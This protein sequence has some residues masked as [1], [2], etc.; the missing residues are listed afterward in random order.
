METVPQVLNDVVPDLEGTTTLLTP[1]LAQTLAEDAFAAVDEAAHA[2]EEDFDD[3]ELDGPRQRHAA[4]KGPKTERKLV[5]IAVSLPVSTLVHPRSVFKGFLPPAPLTT[6]RDAIQRLLQADPAQ[7]DGDFIEFELENFACYIHNTNSTVPFEMRALH[8]HACKSG[9]QHFYFDGILRVGDTRLYVHEIMFEEIPLGNYGKELSTVDDQLW[10]RSKLNQLKPIYYQ[11]KKPSIEY[12]R[13]HNAFLWV[14][15]L[16]KHVVDFCEWYIDNRWNISIH[17]FKSDFADWLKKTHQKDPL[18]LNWYTKRE[19]DDFRQSLVANHLFIR[20]EVRGM[21]KASDFNRLHVF[22]EMG[23]PFC[24]Y[25]RVGMDPARAKKHDPVPF[26]IVTPYIYKCFSHMGLD[27]LLRAVEPSIGTEEAIK[28]SWPRS[29][30]ECLRFARTPRI[31]SDR[32]AMIDSIKPGDLISTPP[33]DSGTGT[34]WRTERA[35]KKWFGLVQKVHLTKKEGR[36]FDVAWLYQPD[37]TPC[38]AAK[39]PWEN[40]LFLSNHCTCSQGAMAKIDEDEVLQVH[41]VE[42]FGTPETSAEFFV[43]QLY[44]TEARRFVTLQADHLQCSHDQKPKPDFNIGDTVLVLMPGNGIPELQPFE[45][46]QYMDGDRTV[47]LRRFRRRKEFDSSCA[48]N[49]LVYTEEETSSWV[50]RITTRCIIRFYDPGQPIPAPYSRHGAGNAFYITHRLLSDGTVHPLDPS[51]RPKLRE[52]FD[53]LKRQ[54]KLRSLDLFCGC[55]NFGRGVEDSGA[56]AAKWAN[57]IKSSAIHTYMANVDPRSCHP[58]L[59]SIDDLL[60]QSMQGKF[61]DSVPR[62]GEVDVVLGG[63]PCQGFSMLTMNKM[64]LQQY[65]NRSLVASFAACIDYWRPRWGILENVTSIVKSS[66]KRRDTEDFFSQLICA[67]IGMGY[68]AQIILGDAWSYGQPQRRVRAFL[69]FAAPGVQLP[70]PPYPSH[71]TPNYINAVG[72]GKMTNGEAY[73]VRDLDQPTAFQYVSASEATADLPDIYDAKTETCIPYPDHRLSVPMPSGSLNGHG[74]RGKSKRTQFLNIPITPYGVN[75]AR[76]YYT[77][78]TS[79]GDVDMFEHE[80]DAF[81]NARSGRCTRISNGWGRAHPRQLFSTITTVC[82]PTDARVGGR[83]S[84]W[85]QPRHLSVMEVRRAQGIPDEEVV[86][87]TAAEQWAMVGNAV[88]RGIS[89]ALGLSLR[90]AWLGTL[91]E[92]GSEGQ[93][94][95]VG[96]IEE[97]R[98]ELVLLSVPATA[99]PS[100]SGTSSPVVSECDTGP[101]HGRFSSTTPATSLA[102]TPSDASSMSGKRSLSKMLAAGLVSSTAFKRPKLAATRV[103][104]DALVWSQPDLAEEPVSAEPFDEEDGLV[105]LGETMPHAAQLLGQERERVLLNDR[106]GALERDEKEMDGDRRQLPP[107]EPEVASLLP[108]PDARPLSTNGFTVVRLS[109]DELLEEH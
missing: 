14:A 70:Q 43:R 73:V 18:F 36:R 66:M 98:D 97:D 105:L 89:M 56:V 33:D 23:M 42:W 40:E 90:E 86:L 55:G 72:L 85:E 53:P 1:G 28:L 91:Y 15:D 27:Q 93:G 99:A 54:Q 37:D 108:R 74:G 41:S 50:N 2:E 24:M 16:A 95:S 104:E 82:H 77:P 52:G 25:K 48:P 32:Q 62:P 51:N 75:F 22:Q 21:L 7:Q 80:R 17:H 30:S 64:S 81:P 13:F 92:D 87:G 44:T 96:V 59:G 10:I 35:D 29:T 9:E 47:R 67:L 88:A 34:K 63:S 94:L 61:G 106:A 100:P 8:M 26:T 83:S 109:S 79:E 19:S 6:E 20:K 103:A 107:L 101:S 60:H 102:E 5:D 71:S 31:F 39:Y 4:G 49:E 3:S 68:Q 46:L 58:F 65:K 11:L 57:D 38:C 78:R 12:A 76:A 69:Y 45:L 84:H